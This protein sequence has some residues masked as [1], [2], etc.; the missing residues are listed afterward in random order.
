MTFLFEFR[1]A[2][3]PIPIEIANQLFVEWLVF[4][5]TERL[6][7]TQHGTGTAEKAKTVN[8]DRKWQ[9]CWSDFAV[10]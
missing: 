10:R 8:A 3:L 2:D 6:G 9:H 7:A 5:T 4:L 1:Q